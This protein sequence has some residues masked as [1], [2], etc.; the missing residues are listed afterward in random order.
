MVSL[1]SGTLEMVKRVRPR[2]TGVPYV[3]ADQQLN[4]PRKVIEINFW[5]YKQQVHK[6]L[7]RE[8]FNKKEKKNKVGK[9]F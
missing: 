8:G 5:W 6:N 4:S 2:P 1:G 9:V 3:Y 7:L